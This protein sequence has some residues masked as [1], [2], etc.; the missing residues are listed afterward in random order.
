VDTPADLYKARMI[1]DKMY[2]LQSGK[3]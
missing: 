1:F 3:S 2:P